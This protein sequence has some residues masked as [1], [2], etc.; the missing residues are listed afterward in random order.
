[1]QA[2]TISCAWGNNSM[3]FD[4]VQNLPILTPSF[5]LT[6]TPITKTQLLQIAVFDSKIDSQL[7]PE[8]QANP[9]SLAMIYRSVPSLWSIEDII[10]TLQKITL[11]NEEQA[12]WYTNIFGTVQFRV[13]NSILEGW[14]LTLTIWGIESLSSAQTQILESAL[15]KTLLQFP[16]ITAVNIRY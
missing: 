12:A 15:Q 2:T 6:T 5:G 16:Q 14:T 3:N 1:M 9:N 10:S 13:I 4:T 11:T 7:P 8:Q